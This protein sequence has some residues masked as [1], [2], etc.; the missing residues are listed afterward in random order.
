MEKLIQEQETNRKKRNQNY[1]E[2]KTK[3]GKLSSG[4]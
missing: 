1:V 2:T 3:K 4:D